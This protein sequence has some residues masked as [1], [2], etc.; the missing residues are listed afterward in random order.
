MNFSQKTSRATLFSL[1]LSLITGAGCSPLPLDAENLDSSDDTPPVVSTDGPDS[2]VQLPPGPD[3]FR[4]LAIEARRDLL[5]TFTMDAAGLTLI[6]GAQGTTLSFFGPDSLQNSAGD[7]VTGD[8]TIELI[9]VFDKG[10]MLVTDMPSIGQLP[11][12]EI[13]QLVSGGEH[14][15]NATQDGE[16]LELRDGFFMTAPVAVTE[17]EAGR[18]TMFRPV[19]EDGD[20]LGF[21]GQGVWVEEEVD[22]DGFGVAGE[23]GTDGNARVASTEYWAFSS[24]FGW[25]NIDRWYSDPRAKTTIHVE[26]PAGWDDSNCAVYL[27][28]D[29]EPTALARFDSYDAA[30]ELFT[31]HYGLIPIGLE[32]H[33]ILV[34]E[35]E[36]EWSYA[37][38]AQTIEEDH[39]VVF[40]SA[41]ALIETDMAGLTAVINGLP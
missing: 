36:G 40:D 20:E 12:G 2:E 10:T 31:E 21:E 13:A 14:F 34:T 4:S 22:L 25:S 15:I 32:V 18:M 17:T 11:S 37:V 8:V 3:D 29:N 30:E 23:Q 33:V 6:E 5:Q 28:Y 35:S 7:T 39:L 27:S 41:A 1:T 24:Q 16:Q 26:V 19:D 9:E 38:Q